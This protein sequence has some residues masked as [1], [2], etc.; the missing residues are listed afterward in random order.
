MTIHEVEV[1][2][3]MPDKAWKNGPSSGAS[4]PTATRTRV[5]TYLGL[6][7]LFSSVFYALIIHAGSLGAGGGSYVRGLMWCPALAAFATCAWRGKDL[8]ELGWG[9]GEGR[10]QWWSYLLPLGYAFVAYLA[11]WLAGWGGFPQWGVVP[12]I[13]K[14]F[15]W[16]GLPPSF[17]LAGYILFTGS[18]GLVGSVSSG[19]GEEIGWRGFL[20]PELM[21]HLG[22]T[23]TALLTGVIWATWHVPILVGADYNN[24]TPTWYGLT[25]FAVMVIAISFPF[26]WL[27]MRSGSLWSAALLHGSHNLFVQAIFTPLTTPKGKITPYAIDEFG[28]ALPLMTVLVAVY[29]WRRRKEVEHGL[30][31]ASTP[32][33]GDAALRLEPAPVARGSESA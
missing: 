5:L 18:I 27:R 1:N 14:S 21:P 4:M 17:V 20:V 19:L 28:F 13:A 6:T 22:F 26:A 32:T 12:G 25:C 9:W 23:R 10:W 15:G 2:E 33:D 31:G 11:V 16:T 7:A 8:R 24:G 3:A 29:F 30:E